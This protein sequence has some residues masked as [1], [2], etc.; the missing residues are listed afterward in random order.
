VLFS[1]VGIYV[2]RKGFDVLIRAFAEVRRERANVKLALVGGEGEQGM[3]ESYSALAE[4]LGVK[5][6]MPEKFVDDV[7]NWLWASDV[8]V[9]PSREE[10]FSIALLEGLASG[11]PAI[12]SDIEPFTEIISPEKHN[13]LIFE[14]DN[15]QSLASAMMSM[16]EQR[17]AIA[18][19][20]LRTVQTNFT[21]EIAAAKTLQVYSNI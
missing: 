17:K 1:G 16:L 4:D 8:L 20:S 7:R 14:K 9:M 13:G 10:G 21:P 18:A 11:L 3:R 12:V 15:H 19:N 2:Q 5:I 6:I